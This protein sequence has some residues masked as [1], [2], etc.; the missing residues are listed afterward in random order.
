MRLIGVADR[1]ISSAL[2]LIANHN[3]NKDS[4]SISARR[5]RIAAHHGDGIS[6]WPGRRSIATAAIARVLFTME[7]PIGEQRKFALGV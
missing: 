3:E 5:S 7:L 1:G 4:N 6:C 2:R